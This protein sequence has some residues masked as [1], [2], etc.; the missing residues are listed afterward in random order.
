M[1]HPD[2][3]TRLTVSLPSFNVRRPCQR[4]FL[5]LLSTFTET[6]ELWTPLSA[7]VPSPAFAFDRDARSLDAPVS[8]RSFTCSRLSLR[9]SRFAGQVQGKSG[10]R[11]QHALIWPVE[12]V[13]K[14]ED[15]HDAEANNVVIILSPVLRQV[16]LNI[17]DSQIGNA[18]DALNENC[19]VRAQQHRCRCVENACGMTV[20]ALYMH[21]SWL[22]WHVCH[23]ACMRNTRRTPQRH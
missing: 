23:D 13:A 4:P 22:H 3:V 14:V 9:R 12:K 11:I 20:H 16:A 5:H 2:T 8:L 19:M 17:R 1:N 18:A 10:K 15:Y 21:V 7:F 6:L